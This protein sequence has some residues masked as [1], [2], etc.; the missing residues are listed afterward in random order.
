MIDPTAFAE[1]YLDTHQSV[2]PEPTFIGDGTFVMLDPSDRTQYI[3]F[4]Y[5]PDDDSCTEQPC[6]L[7]PGGMPPRTPERRPAEGWSA[8]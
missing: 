1:Y 8:W 5:E 2:E 7:K 4:W 6:W 3:M